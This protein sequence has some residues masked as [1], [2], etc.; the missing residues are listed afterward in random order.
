MAD[1][2]EDQERTISIGGRTIT[3]LRFADDIDGLAGQEQELV[4]LPKHL[5]GASKA[6][7]MQIRAEKT[8][9]MTNN[10]NVFSTDTTIANK[11]LETVHSFKYLATIVS[12][13]EPKPGVISRI[14]QTTA[15]VIKIKVIWN[16]K[17]WPSTSR[18]D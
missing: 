4:S 10:T 6:Y 9:L 13:D 12:D 7:V 11:K 3:N 15:A 17:T 5:D 14:A 2:L 18:S 1:A 16:N 8:Q